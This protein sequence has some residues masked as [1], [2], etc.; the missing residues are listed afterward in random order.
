MI[1]E[2]YETPYAGE[3]TVS[4]KDQLVAAFKQREF[5]EMFLGNFKNFALF[6]GASAVIA[7]YFED[8]ANSEDLIKAMGI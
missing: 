2:D 7:T 4:I 8:F 6:L 5:R 3:E 1:D